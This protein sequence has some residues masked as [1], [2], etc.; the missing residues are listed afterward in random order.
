MVGSV[1]LSLPN[2]YAVGT[3]K[4]ATLNQSVSLVCADPLTVLLQ[5]GTTLGRNPRLK[6]VTFGVAVSASGKPSWNVLV[7]LTLQPDT[8]LLVGPWTPDRNS[9]PCRTEDPPHKP[10][11]GVG[12]NQSR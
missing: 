11:S 3:V 1:R 9:C 12:G 2:V 4:H 7:P 6:P 8:T 5:P 10:Q